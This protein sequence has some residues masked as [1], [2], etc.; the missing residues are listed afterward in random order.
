MKF[1]LHEK[2]KYMLFGGLLVLTGSMFGNMSSNTAAQLGSETID[3]L[4]VR[5]LKVTEN[6]TLYDGFSP[7]VHIHHNE[8]GG[9]VTIASRDE[10]GFAKMGIAENGGEIVTI[11]KE[12][13]GVIISSAEDMDGIIEVYAKGHKKAVTIS[14]VDAGGYVSTLAKTG[15]GTVVLAIVKGDGVVVTQDKFGRI[16]AFPIE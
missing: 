16:N 8:H 10:S 14:N 1:R 11:S 7:L 4:T 2:L 6:I 15:E 9:Q 12:S 13:G 3:E 5:K